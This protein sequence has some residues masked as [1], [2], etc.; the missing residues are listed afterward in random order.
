MSYLW[1]FD[2]SRLLLRPFA[3]FWRENRKKYIWAASTVGPWRRQQGGQ[4]KQAWKIQETDS[5]QCMAKPL[6]YCKVN[7][8][9]LKWI[10]LLK[11]NTGERTQ[12]NW[13]SEWEP[14]KTIQVTECPCPCCCDCLFFACIE[15]LT[16]YWFL[17]ADPSNLGSVRWSPWSLDKWMTLTED[18]VKS[19]FPSELQR[20]IL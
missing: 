15:S 13:E 10:N 9:Q 20:R 3:I 18:Q 8:I 7:S 2:G 17:P 6:Q 19:E 14:A 16:G 11:K 4:L 12:W 1:W 5:W